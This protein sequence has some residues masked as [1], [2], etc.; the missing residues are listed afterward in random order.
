MKIQISQQSHLTL[1]ESQSN[2]FYHWVNNDFFQNNSI[3]DDKTS[4]GYFN[5]L[6]QTSLENQHNL[7]NNLSI[8]KLD[9]NH[10]QHLLQTFW[11]KCSNIY[12]MEDIPSLLNFCKS[13]V[14]RS[15]SE[16]LGYFLA[17]LSK[18]GINPFI[19][20]G[21]TFDYENSDLIIAGMGFGGLT[22]SDRDYYFNDE[23]KNTREDFKNYLK[24]LSDLAG[25]NFEDIFEYE[26]EIA[27]WHYTKEEKRDPHKTYNPHNLHE[28]YE[29][30]PL[31]NPFLETNGYLTK[32]ADA[33]H[34]I[35][36]SNPNGLKLLLEKIS[37][38]DEEFMQKVV[39]YKLVKSWGSLFS[40]K[41]DDLNFDFFGKKING[42]KKQKK[43]WERKVRLI[44]ANLG[45]L[46]GLLYT[47]KY[48]N[49]E[50]KT[51]ANKMVKTMMDTFH[52]RI[53][54]LH[55]MQQS[56][57]NLAL[58]KL[59]KMKIKLGYPEVI[60][61]YST[62]D[63]TNCA[64]IIEILQEVDRWQYLLDF[65]EMYKP[66]NREKWE[67]NPQTVNAYFH[68]LLNEI[69]FP[70]AILQPPFFDKD[71]GIEWNYGGIGMVICH[72]I[73]HA[74]DDKGR[75][76]DSN[77]NLNDWWQKEDTE[78]FE[79]AI[80]TYEEQFNKLEVEGVKIKA[81]L[82]MGEALAD[83]GGVNVALAALKSQL[84]NTEEKDENGFTPIHRFFLSVARVWA[85]IRTPEYSKLLATTDPHPHPLHRVNITLANTEDFY[86]T[87]GKE[88]DAMYVA[89]ENRL[90]LW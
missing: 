39:L 3:P 33:Q 70:A 4:W 75:K 7:L 15:Y 43:I 58:E 77:G 59:Q 79:K 6:D 78:K 90:V 9:N 88:T 62:M 69:V 80:A 72:E 42:Q 34:K 81:G 86:K 64:S 68:P 12:E 85:N 14:S 16:N 21:S 19:Y 82:V 89:A 48:F 24:D 44:N 60:E 25:E 53:S 8:N 32:F 57:K 18:N 45:E 5:I 51:T 66:P 74:F 76:F 50:C 30:S 10:H 56:T 63:F 52:Q 46:I 61:D 17:N 55:W 54:N 20:F 73:T 47:K 28:L 26:K 65:E 83:H 2:N 13:L 49:E 35:N 29:I 38:M 1:P 22:L 27:E 67:M 11:G 87:F 40:R 37:C 31:I 71:A 36:V 23:H 41:I 84:E